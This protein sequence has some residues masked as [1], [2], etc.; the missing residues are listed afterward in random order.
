[1][2]PFKSSLN[3]LGQHFTRRIRGLC[4]SVRGTF[5]FDAV[6]RPPDAHP[7]GVFEQC[8]VTTGHW[9]SL[10]FSKTSV[11]RRVTAFPGDALLVTSNTPLTTKVSASSTW[12][13][14]SFWTIL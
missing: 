3:L 11:Q 12:M 5:Q 6:T 13:T 8:S 7:L 9:P 14:R 4:E 1:M 2:N 10:V